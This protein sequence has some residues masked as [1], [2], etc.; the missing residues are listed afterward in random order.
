MQNLKVKKNKHTKQHKKNHLEFSQSLGGHEIHPPPHLFRVSVLG[1]FHDNVFVAQQA[2][3]DVF[4]Q[5]RL[6]GEG[7]VEA[8]LS[9]LLTMLLRHFNTLCCCRQALLTVKHLIKTKTHFI[10]IFFF[11]LSHA[12][13]IYFKAAA[14]N[15][16]TKVS[17]SLPPLPTCLLNASTNIL[18][19]DLDQTTKAE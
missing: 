8:D 12:P 18:M 13:L 7:Q 19:A 17:E 10:R 15:L 2:C 16:P 6:Q 3:L 1:G 9:Q 14:L 5:Q 4:D 11:R